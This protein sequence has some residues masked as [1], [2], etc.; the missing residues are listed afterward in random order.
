MFI[1]HNFYL[2]ISGDFIHRPLAHESAFLGIAVPSRSGVHGSSREFR[3]CQ[4]H[5]RG[6]FPLVLAA[7]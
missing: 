2:L 7:L 5:E 4:H 1:L 6:F 3:C